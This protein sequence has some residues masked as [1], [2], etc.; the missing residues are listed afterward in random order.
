MYSAASGEPIGVSFMNLLSHPSYDRAS[1]ESRSL[2]CNG[3]GAAGA[4]FDFVP[5]AIWGLPIQEA[6]FR[7]DWRYSIGTTEEEKAI[8]DIE[9]LNNL[10]ILINNTK[11]F[12]A[13]M[14]RIPRRRRALKYYEMVVS[15]GDKAYW[16]G[17]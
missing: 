1:P 9:F 5:D 2:V 10:M 6:C 8:A 3:C 11:G 13:T 4:K 12:T 16:A 14:L 7:H 17:K 15:F